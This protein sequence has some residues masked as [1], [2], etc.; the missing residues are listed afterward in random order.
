MGQNFSQFGTQCA[1]VSP[2]L[3][4]AKYGGDGATGGEVD[5]DCARLF[6]VGRNLKNGGAAQAAMCDQHLLAKLLALAGSDYIGRDPRKIAIAR[7]IFGLQHEWY[8]RRSGLANGKTEL[9]R[10]LIAQGSSPD[11]GN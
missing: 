11:L 7:T 2:R 8:E 10:N 6:P 4:I 1:Q 9:A 5:K 3:G